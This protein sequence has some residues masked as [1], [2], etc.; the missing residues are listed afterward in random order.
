MSKCLR[1]CGTRDAG[2]S[3]VRTLNCGQDTDDEDGDEIRTLGHW[4]WAPSN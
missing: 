2:D 3:R 1:K 4:M